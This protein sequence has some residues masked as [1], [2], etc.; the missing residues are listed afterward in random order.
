MG[1]FGYCSSLPLRERIGIP[2]LA[3]LLLA[4]IG[5]GVDMVIRPSRHIQGR[6]PLGG[7]M[8][9]DLNETQVQIFALLLIAGAAWGLYEF[10]CD[11]W[12]KCFRA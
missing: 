9:R 1:F 3:L 5:L 4:A 12:V 10:I 6:M 7:E 2:V 11:V 8:L